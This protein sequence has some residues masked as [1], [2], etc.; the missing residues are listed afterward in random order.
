[1]KLPWDVTFFILLSQYWAQNSQLLIFIV[2]NNT[3]THFFFPCRAVPAR[4]SACE[5]I[6]FLLYTVLHHVYGFQRERLLCFRWEKSTNLRAKCRFQVIHLCNNHPKWENS[7]RKMPN[8]HEIISMQGFHRDEALQFC[9][10]L[11]R[12][13]RFAFQI[14]VVCKYSCGNSPGFLQA[15]RIIAGARVKSVIWFPRI[16]ASSWRLTFWQCCHGHRDSFA[17]YRE[18]KLQNAPM[19]FFFLI[20]ISITFMQ[21]AKFWNLTLS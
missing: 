14:S 19:I 18:P 20:S 11:L 5:I 7:P 4:S 8:S 9:V 10:V 13:R 12:S 3:Y 2:K 16:S 17:I 15:K 1:M 6:T 21:T